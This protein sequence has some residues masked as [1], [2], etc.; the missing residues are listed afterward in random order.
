MME[1]ISRGNEFLVQ[2]DPNPFS[3]SVVNQSNHIM[4]VVVYQEEG[5]VYEQYL[6]RI[7]HNQRKLQKHLNQGDKYEEKMYQSTFK[8][9]FTFNVLL[10]YG[11]CHRNTAY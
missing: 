2:G 10:S 1:Y 3:I 4:N 5:D 9:A 8:F 6:K 11:Y 7:L